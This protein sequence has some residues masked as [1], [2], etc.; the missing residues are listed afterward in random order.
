MKPELIADYACHTGEGPLWHPGEKRLYWLDIPAGRIFRYTPASGTHE[1]VHEGEAIGGF[2]IQA[3]GALLLFMARGAITIWREGTLTTAIDEI[4]DERES[5]F[6]DVIADPAG[7]VFCGTMPTEDRLGRLYRL[8]LDGT[9]TRVLDGITCSN[10]MG[11]SPDRKHMYYTDSHKYEIYVFDYDEDTGAIANQR[12]F[13]RAPKGEGVPDGLTVDEAGY[14][15][16]AHWDGNCLV[17]YTPDGVE[18]RRIP[19][20]A[21]KVSSLTFGG[22][23]YTDIYITTA[24]GTSKE[25][26][27][28]G[29]G[30]L[31]RVNP[32]I[33]GV[34]EFPSRI[35]L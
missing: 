17:R 23:D 5:R 8:D 26:E 20:P 32:G 2:T 21:P 4:P 15:W 25:T 14:V 29:A 18:D 24:G 12:L 9:L 22:E 35:G 16:S 34:P 33:R 19:L 31:F 6:N 30:A 10:G 1:Q 27:G 28:S 3:D 7:R 11:F 13:V